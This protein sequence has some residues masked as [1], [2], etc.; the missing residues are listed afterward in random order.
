[1]VPKKVAK[2]YL[3]LAI[4]WTVATAGV[5]AGIIA[6]LPGIA[7]MPALLF[8]LCAVCALCWW[9]SFIREKKLEKKEE[10]KNP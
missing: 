1:M 5:A 2:R 10:K 4:I 9:G 3:T 7:P 8:G 6:C